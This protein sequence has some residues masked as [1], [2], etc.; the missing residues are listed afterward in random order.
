MTEFDELCRALG[1]P[2]GS[3]TAEK[4]RLLRAR[5]EELKSS[6][7]H[8]ESLAFSIAH[9]LRAPLGHLNGYSRILLEEMS[10]RLDAQGVKI[11]ERIEAASQR[12]SHMIDALIGLAHRT[13]HELDAAEVDLSGEVTAIA[14]ELHW[15]EPER[16]VAF[17]IDAGVRGVGDPQLLRVVLQN[18]VGN[19]WK[20]TAGRDDATIRFGVSETEH[21]PAAYVCDNGVGFDMGFANRL[22]KPFERL[23]RGYAGTGIGLASVERI[24]TRHGGRVWAKGKV[25]SGATFYFTLPRLAAD[26]SSSGNR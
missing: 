16:S 17:Q 11:L 20:F 25:D 26:D 10:S 6:N 23:H 21:G 5:V 13:S 9:D 24:I 4:V 1:V 15:L 22:F 2:E 8:L 19:A 14:A 7:R 3:L 12:M 18:L